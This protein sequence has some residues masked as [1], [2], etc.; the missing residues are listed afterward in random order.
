MRCCVKI[1]GIVILPG[2]LCIHSACANVYSSTPSADTHIRGGSPSGL[3]YGIAWRLLAGGGGGTEFYRGIYKWS[4]PTEINGAQV[5]SATLTFKI[6]SNTTGGDYYIGGITQDWVEGTQWGN[7]PPPPPDGATD[8]TSDGST[9]WPYLAPLTQQA[10]GNY[11]YD[12]QTVP[13][14]AS[15]GDD[16]V[17]GTVVFDVT[18][19]VQEWADGR[20]NYGLALAGVSPQGYMLVFSRETR[21][22]PTL[23]ITY[24]TKKPYL[25]ADL[26][27]DGYVNLIDAKDLAGKWL[28]TGP[29]LEPDFDDSLDVDFLDYAKLADYWQACSDPDS[30]NCW[31]N[32]MHA[33]DIEAGDILCA[34][35]NQWVGQFTVKVKD[36]NQQPV[37]NALVDVSFSGVH[38]AGD[39][40]VTDGNGEVV[41]TTDCSSGVGITTAQIENISK[42]G[43]W[44]DPYMNTAS[45]ESI[46]GG[47]P[48]LIEFGQGAPDARML[49]QNLASFESYLPFDGLVIPV[50]RD[51]YAGRYNT[52]YIGDLHPQY[53]PIST[54]AFRNISVSWIDYYNTILD[55]QQIH[56]QAQKFKH[57]F[58]LL[59]CYH[60]GLLWTGGNGFYMDWFDDN[61]WNIVENNLSSLAKIAFMGGCEGI[62]FDIEHYGATGFWSAS[63]LM[64]AHPS[65]P[66]DFDSWRVQVKQR[67]QEFIVAVNDEFPAIKLILSYGSGITHRYNSGGTSAEQFAFY[68]PSQGAETNVAYGLISA[69]IDGML[70][71]ADPNTEIIDGYESSYYFKEQWEFD[72]GRDVVLNKCR[73]YSEHPEL[74]T[75]KVRMGG[76]LYLMSSDPAKSF[77]TQQANDSVRMGMTAS[78]RYLWLWNERSTFWIQGGA[79]GTP[80]VP[81]YAMVFSS[82][83]AD[84]T[85]PGTVGNAMWN[86]FSGLPQN[87]IDA[88]TTGKNQAL[89][90]E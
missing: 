67:G 72:V 74:Y 38:T 43:M 52:T 36:R 88:V 54:T 45:S 71:G 19:L 30:G 59:E 83:P 47:R 56:A 51:I 22:G 9:P 42:S 5:Q 37:T 82:D 8:V 24:L 33:A 18:E 3:N 73:S 81:D 34:D 70:L 23:D 16:Q 44:Y 4:L 64:A 41:L 28:F 63:E 80:L 10:G 6:H 32:L 35:I 12:T 84:L 13:Q 55:L 2:F 85:T 26:I 62:F 86:D 76:A 20:G 77:T 7:L 68:N 46:Y 75:D 17:M 27:Q 87:M 57:N 14:L 21:Y 79:G 53:W 61:Y 58:V 29:G 40:G 65:R 49:L 89:G 48:L 1:I 11:Q 90:Q 66:Q 25:Q 69:F 50:N 39:S 78:D 60:P 31:G 15:T